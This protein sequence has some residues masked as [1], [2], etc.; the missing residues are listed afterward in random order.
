MWREVLSL[1]ANFLYIKKNENRVLIRLL[2]VK[3]V[4]TNIIISWDNKKSKEIKFV[5]DKRNYY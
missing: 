5:G 4:I 3:S 1:H 2:F